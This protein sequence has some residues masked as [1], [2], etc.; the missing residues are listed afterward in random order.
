[1]PHAP[2]QGYAAPRARP[3]HLA[4]AMAAPEPQL[5]G[6]RIPWHSSGLDPALKDT[7]SAT[8]GP[9][10]VLLGPPGS[11]KTMLARAMAGILPNLTEKEICFNNKIF[12]IYDA[13][14]IK[15]SWPN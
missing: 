15:Y 1:M 9:C 5:G 14:T 6:T 10:S 2:R 8:R 4:A 12:R 3:I 11:G 7:F 13:G